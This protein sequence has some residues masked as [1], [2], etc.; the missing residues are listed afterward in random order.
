MLTEVSRQ[1]VDRVIQPDECRHPRMIFRQTGRFDL[2][3][4]FQRVREIA[5]R[6]QVREPV[7]DA[8]R[9]I[10][11]LANLARRAASAVTDHVRSHC[12]AVFAVT[13]I[14]FLDHRFATIAAGK[15]EI[16]IRPAFA[17]LI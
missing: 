15:I 10:Q 5:V 8:R 16:D 2:R 9:K 6:E 14:N 3:F 13:A 4:Q 1:A 12:G 11:R 17:A 7:N